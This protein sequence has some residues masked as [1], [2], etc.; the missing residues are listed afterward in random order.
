M[1]AGDDD[2]VFMIRSLN[3]MPKTTEQHLIVRSV[4][5]K[6]KSIKEECAQVI[7]LLKLTTNRHEASRSLSATQPLVFG[8]TQLV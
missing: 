3:V 8:F 4:N 6:L 5:L 7:V 1:G 2:E